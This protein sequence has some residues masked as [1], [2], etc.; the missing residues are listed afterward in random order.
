MAEILDG[1]LLAEMIKAELRQKVSVIKAERGWVPG[2][3]V[4]LVGD[5]P[6]S[7][8]YVKNKLK[9]AEDLGV[10]AF[11]FYLEADTTEFVL[12]EQLERLNQDP[13]IDGI[14]IQL[15]LPKHINANRVLAKIAV[16][17]DIDGFHAE[18]IGKLALKQP[19][20]HPCTP[21]GIM[22]L[23]K[24]YVG[25]ILGANAVVVG[26]SNIVGRPMALELLN[27]GCTVTI[28]HRSTRNLQ[29][30]TRRADILV[31]AAGVPHLIDA[32]MVKPGAIVVDVGIHRLDSGKLTGD[33]DFES[34]A[35]I[36]A[37]IS[38]VPGGV[39]PM[40][41]A[42]LMQNLVLAS[43]AHDHGEALVVAEA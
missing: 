12:L 29:E 5:D 20:L 34:V 41:I 38:P 6:A 28:C 8:V 36:A 2:I 27:A 26:A 30:E 23:L 7:H 40:T 11:S 15:P 43:K 22:T 10:A 24:Y 19:G 18:N 42:T 14:L 21:K 3:A 25:D 4:I 32:S 16:D 39:G 33:V 13:I 31:V 9:Y 1:K 37:W 17:K 35:P